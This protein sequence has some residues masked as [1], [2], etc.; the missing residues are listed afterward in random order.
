MLKIQSLLRQIPLVNG[1]FNWFTPAQNNSTGR[2]FN[3]QS[4]KIA[5]TDVIYKYHMQV[6]EIDE[7]KKPQETNE[8]TISQKSSSHVRNSSTA[9]SSKSIIINT[10]SEESKNESKEMKQ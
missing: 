2:T 4:G 9:S 6:E 1:F 7:Q 3:L 10:D 8:D 5:S